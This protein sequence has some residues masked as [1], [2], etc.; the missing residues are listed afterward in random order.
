MRNHSLSIT[1]ALAA[2]LSCS[3]AAFA[4]TTQPSKAVHAPTP[5]RTPD[6]SGV[7]MQ[8]RPA[9]ALREK[10]TLKPGDVIT[11][12]GHRAKNANVLRLQKIVLPDGREM[13]NL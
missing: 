9:T 4:Q 6:F 11:A 5:R 12:S 1:L 13:A 2:L 3:S 10:S 7:W 8:D